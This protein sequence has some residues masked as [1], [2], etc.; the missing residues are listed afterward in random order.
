MLKQLLS[1]KLL[2]IVL[3]FGG[4]FVIGMIADQIRQP[5]RWETANECLDRAPDRLTNTCDFAVTYQ[6]CVAQQGEQKS[7]CDPIGELAPGANATIAPV[8]ADDH[9]GEAV[10]VEIAGALNGDASVIVQNIA[11]QDEPLGRV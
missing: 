6:S 5:G 11:L 3:V 8:G 1:N 2:L 9:I 4:V 7:I 10:A